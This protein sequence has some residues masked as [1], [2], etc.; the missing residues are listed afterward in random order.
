[1][2]QATNNMSSTRKKDQPATRKRIALGRMDF[3]AQLMRSPR[4]KPPLSSRKPRPTIY[5]L[6]NKQFAIENGH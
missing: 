5:P 4:N 2:F 6:V 1:M 3:M